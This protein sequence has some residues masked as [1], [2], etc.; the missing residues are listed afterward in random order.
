MST[1]AEE[2]AGAN[3]RAVTFDD[4]GAADVLGEHSVER[5]A[6]LPSEVLV[7]VHAVGLNPVD[8][9]TRAGAPTPARAALGS[10]PHILGWDVSGVVESVGHG[11]HRFAP[12]DEVFGLIWFPRPGNAYAEYVTAPSRQFA[13]KPGSVDHVHAAAVPLAALTAWHALVEVALVQP[14]QRVLIHAAAGG[15][16][17]FAVQMAR[18][19]GAHVIG[20]AS[21][22][23]AD[24]LGRLGVDEHVD[25]TSVRF[26]DV[27][28]PVDVVLDL[29]GDMH[30]A[31]TS[32]S[33]SV[34]R[35]GGVLVSIAPGAAP[36]LPERAAGLG[37]RVSPPILVE[38]DGAG[39]ETIAGLIDQGA[40]EVLVEEVFPLEDAAAAHRLG[41]SGRVSGKLVLSVR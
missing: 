37:V 35:P 27:I 4:F 31:T 38:P 1:H 11:V 18:H 36:D 26:E 33:L 29:V 40:I 19:L 2:S 15:V 3:M 12:G 21:A 22:A 13:R 16:G 20:T 14:G 23:K 39:L 7:R 24:L 17:H 9:K 5:P 25:Y 8:W 28:A 41:D 34:L 10:A 32:R 6:A 30:D